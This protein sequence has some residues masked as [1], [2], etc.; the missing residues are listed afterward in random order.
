[1][2][3]ESPSI[4]GDAGKDQGYESRRKDL[5]HG[6]LTS[7]LMLFKATA[8]AA[9]FSFNFFM[10]QAGISYGWLIAEI[11]GLLCVYAMWR[12]SDIADRIEAD[13]SIRM[14]R[15]ENLNSRY[16]VAIETTKK[17]EAVKERIIKRFQGKDNCEI[18]TL[19]IPI[20]VKIKGANIFLFATLTA[21]FCMNIVC[22]I[23]NLQLS[24][25]LYQ[26]ALGINNVTSV[27]AL[28]ISH[29]L[30][31]IAVVEPEKLKPL[32][33]LVCFIELFII[34]SFI[35][36]SGWEL[37]QRGGPDLSDITWVYLPALG[38]MMGA[39]AYGFESNGSMLSS[40]TYY[41]MNKFGGQ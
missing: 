26:E 3:I 6:Y 30:V 18:L 14:D 1:M 19:D 23:G 33:F 28:F 22:C 21:S 24:N 4:I 29:S 32:T 34:F 13:T 10:G 7:G 36:D 2:P 5:R 38:T 41:L 31:I 15:V 37:I 25:I 40:K 9:S 11:T 20:L 35:G 39:T 12:L 17:S 16:H 27:A 8:G